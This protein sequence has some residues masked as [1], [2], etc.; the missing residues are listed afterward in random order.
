M[1]ADVSVL[2]ARTRGRLAARGL[3][4]GDR[5]AR[6]IRV[7]LRPSAAKFSCRPA[8]PRSPGIPKL[9]TDKR[10]H[11]MH[12]DNAVVIRAS[13]LSQIHDRRLVFGADETPRLRRDADETADRG[14]LGHE[15]QDRMHREAVEVPPSV[16]GVPCCDGGLTGSAGETTK[17]RRDADE[18]RPSGSAASRGSFG[19]R[20][21]PA[22]PPCDFG[23]TPC[24]A[25]IRRRRL[26]RVA[27]QAGM[28]RCAAWR[29][30][31]RTKRRATVGHGSWRPGPSAAG[32]SPT[33]VAHRGPPFVLRGEKSAELPASGT[34]LAVHS[35]IAR[36]NSCQNPMQRGA[37]RVPAGEARPAVASSDCRR[38]WRQREAVQPPR[39]QGAELR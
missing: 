16:G 8:A 2:A 36:R 37:T 13:A 22:I 1:D 25:E 14:R 19:V 3:R 30:S 23:R 31:P 26:R 18:T 9:R 12:R 10:R 15:R 6:I 4:L 24:Q 28:V 33:P 20:R 5:A 38:G 35:Q 32:Q 27:H 34:A 17:W 29:F 21:P 11:P 39:H 7:H